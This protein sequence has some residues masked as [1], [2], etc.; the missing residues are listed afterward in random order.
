MQNSNLTPEQYEREI[1]LEPGSPGQRLISGLL[2]DGHW[3]YRRR[4]EAG[5]TSWTQLPMASDLAGPADPYGTDRKS[6]RLNSSH[7]VISYAVYCLSI[8]KLA[9]MR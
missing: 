5:K 4:A 1:P 9:T 6:T 8:N 2:F 7:L 3:Q